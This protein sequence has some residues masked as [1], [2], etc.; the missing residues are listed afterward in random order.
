MNR[1]APHPRSRKTP[2]GRRRMARRILQQSLGTKLCQ[3]GSNERPGS[4]QTGP[5]RGS[6]GGD[7]LRRGERHDD[8]WFSWLVVE[9]VCVCL[10]RG[11]G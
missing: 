8:G 6:R 1:S 11:D 7:S 3:Y 2:R 4:L 9:W 5:A 10:G